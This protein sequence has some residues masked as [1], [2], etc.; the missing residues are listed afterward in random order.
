MQINAAH[1]L[2]CYACIGSLPFV[3]DSA[4]EEPAAGKNVNTV[5]RMPASLIGLIAAATPSTS[6]VETMPSLVLSTTKTEP[7]H[8]GSRSTFNIVHARLYMY[9]TVV[10]CV[11]Y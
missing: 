2:I 8:K 10:E 11:K 9:M 1:L 6:H 7:I 3:A 4:K 5:V